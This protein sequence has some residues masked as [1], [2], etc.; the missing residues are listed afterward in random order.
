MVVTISLMLGVLMVALDKTIICKS[1]PFRNI[2]RQYRNQVL[3]L[4][5]RSNRRPKYH[6]PI[7][8]CPRHRLLQRGVLA[9][10]NVS[11]TNLRQ[12]IQLLQHQAVHDPRIS[13]LWSRL[14][15]LCSL[16][17]N[18]HPRSSPCRNWH[19]SDIRTRDDNHTALCAVESCLGL[20]VNFE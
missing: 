11:L 18:L 6:H 15:N 17:F 19:C 9:S 4:T 7:P 10:H 3:T 13:L 2:C 1:F 12:I 14:S 16:S 8:Q 20:L 5:Y